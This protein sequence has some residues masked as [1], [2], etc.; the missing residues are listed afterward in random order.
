MKATTNKSHV[1]ACSHVTT[2]DAAY[3]MEQN[4]NYEI[5]QGKPLREIG[6]V[7]VEEEQSE[8]EDEVLLGGVGQGT[9]HQL[10]THHGHHK[11][12]TTE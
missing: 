9:A 3:L 8:D 2:N 6:I 1:S 11:S 7:E 10:H 4:G 12:C 5:V